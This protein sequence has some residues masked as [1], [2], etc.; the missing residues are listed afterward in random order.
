MN[1]ST[2][3]SELKNALIPRYGESESDVMQRM[4]SDFL[5]R[6]A[7]APAD[8][9]HAWT[10]D[11]EMLAVLIRSKL[12]TGVPIQYVLQ[13]SWFDGRAFY[14]DESVLIPRPE[15]EELLDWIKKD[16]AAHPLPNNILEIG[17][18]SGILAISL[19][20]AFPTT[21][22][23]AI[24]IEEKAL[25]V[26]RKNA[27]TFQETVQFEQMDFTD[28]NSWHRLSMADLIVSNP[29]YIPWSERHTLSD[30]VL[31]HEPHRALFVPAEDPLLFYRLIA[32]LGRDKLMSAGRIFLEMHENRA[33]ATKNLFEQMGYQATIQ[34]DMQGKK[35]MLRAVYDN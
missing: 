5:H 6:K 3:L 30:H 14:V 8:P 22:V 9:N 33:E 17:T 12:C 4:V 32:E 19:K 18:G 1:A 29:P 21:T 11:I 13:E 24:D 16:T 28:K 34:L 2:F 15:T 23:T 25:N 26:A 20:K 7:F 31:S 10:P 27:H 35:R